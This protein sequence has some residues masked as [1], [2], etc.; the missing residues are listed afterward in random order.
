MRLDWE[1]SL[2]TIPSLS[3]PSRLQAARWGGCDNPLRTV[4]R[5]NQSLRTIPSLSNPSRLQAA[6]WGGC[7]NPLRTV[8]RRNQSL[9]TIPS[10]SNPSRLQAARRGRHRLKKKEGLRSEPLFMPVPIGADQSCRSVT[11]TRW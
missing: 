8:G 3:N 7:D 6:R 5:R 9:R 10:L 11:S 4:G 2:R 1:W